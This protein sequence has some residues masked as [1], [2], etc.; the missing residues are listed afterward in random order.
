MED[1]QNEQVFEEGDS[2]S[3]RD[4]NECAAAKSED[5][6]VDKTILQSQMENLTKSMSSK[7]IIP[8]ARMCSDSEDEPPRQLQHHRLSQVQ[9]EIQQFGGAAVSRKPLHNN[10][11]SQCA[12]QAQ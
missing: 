8:E 6:R 11:Y 5:K 1:P 12:A 9:E 10:N 2:A 7:V 4:G 3:D